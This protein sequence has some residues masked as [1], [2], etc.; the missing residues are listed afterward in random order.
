[1]WQKLKFGMSLNVQSYTE[2][3]LFGLTDILNCHHSPELQR[4]LRSYGSLA[5]WQY[6]PI[7]FQLLMSLSSICLQTRF[8]L[9]LFVLLCYTL[10][11]NI[12]LFIT[13][14]VFIMIKI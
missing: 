1:M 4:L 11:V 13:F 2:L 12:K 10:W 5:E 9:H 8:A 3:W 6:H 7:D 14:I